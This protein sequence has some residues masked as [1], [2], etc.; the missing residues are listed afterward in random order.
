MRIN[1]IETKRIKSIVSQYV[2]I[3][4]RLH[5][6]KFKRNHLMERTQLQ[7]ELKPIEKEVE[8]LCNSEDDDVLSLLHPIKYLPVD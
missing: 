3:C 1:N 4:D 5:E 6:I 8:I 2:N 7:E